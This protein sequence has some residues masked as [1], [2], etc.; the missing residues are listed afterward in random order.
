MD[1][2]ISL[3]GISAGNLIGNPDVLEWKRRNNMKFKILA[4]L[5]PLFAM[6]LSS[7]GI[8]N[9]FGNDPLDGTSWELVAIRENRPVKGTHI[10][11]SFEKGQLSGNSGCN[12]FGGEYRVR[13]NRIEFGVLETTLMA[14]ANPVIMEQESMFTQYLGEAGEFEIVDGQLWVYGAG[15]EA[16]TFIPTQNS[17]P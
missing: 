6:L 12:T 10:T 8:P 4:L 7:C 2:L 17:Y 16:M 1:I 14:C 5:L 9:P 3:R 13:G 11:I 15:G